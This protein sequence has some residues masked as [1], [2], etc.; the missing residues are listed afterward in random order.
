M[1][2][3]R[4]AVKA[5]VTPG[6]A[7]PAEPDSASRPGDDDPGTL[8]SDEGQQVENR[9]ETVSP[10]GDAS[11]LQESSQTET[12]GSSQAGQQDDNSGSP[13]RS[14]DTEPKNKSRKNSE[15]S[16]SGQTNLLL[17]EQKSEGDNGS[18]DK[19]ETNQ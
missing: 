17:D 13:N 5:D 18:P 8:P 12:S 7:S 15:A 3:G 19:G 10:G 11:G 9:R 6:G 2:R 14:Q 4:R 1:T 16:R